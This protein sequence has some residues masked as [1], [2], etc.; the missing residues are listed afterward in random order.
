[1]SISI[2]FNNGIVQATPIV[3][4][5]ATDAVGR[6]ILGLSLNEWFYLSA[7]LYSVAMT[8]VAVYKVLKQPTSLKD[9][10]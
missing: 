9:Q 7:I 8:F 4:A 10:Q 3:G 1:M 6:L 2:D 5:A